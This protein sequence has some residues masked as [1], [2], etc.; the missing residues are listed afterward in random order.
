MEI[1][2]DSDP[3]NYRG[4]IWKTTNGGI[5]WGYQIPDTSIHIGNI[6]ILIS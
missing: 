6:G 3:G 2:I 4:I 5:N 1:H